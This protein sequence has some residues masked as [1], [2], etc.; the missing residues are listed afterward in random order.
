MIDFTSI[1]GADELTLS[2]SEGGLKRKFE[3][4][5]LLPGLKRYVAPPPAVKPARDVAV[6]GDAVERAPAAAAV[7]AAAAAGGAGAGAGA[8]AKVAHAHLDS[9]F[10]E[11]ESD[12]DADADDTDDAPVAKAINPRSPR[13]ARRAAAAGGIDGVPLVQAKV[14]VND[15]PEEDNVASGPLAVPFNNIDNVEHI[16][17]APL[18]A[19]PVVAA[20]RKAAAGPRPDSPLPPIPNDHARVKQAPLVMADYVAPAAAAEVK[21]SAEDTAQTDSVKE[22]SAAQ[23]EAEVEGKEEKVIEAE[24]EV[25]ANVEEDEAEETRIEPASGKR[26]VG[27]RKGRVL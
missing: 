11:D 12:V 15:G 1:G 8:K 5:A 13:E 21:E 6:Q 25:V 2:H 14:H 26:R 27:R 24:T 17:V 19:G 9:M 18:P 22:Q 4:L 3:E 7:P 23:V 10:A 20:P 16:G